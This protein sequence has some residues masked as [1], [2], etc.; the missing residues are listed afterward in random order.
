[1][2]VEEAAQ[3]RPAMA[4]GTG[5]SLL[6]YSQGRLANKCSYDAIEPARFRDT[7]ASCASTGAVTPVNPSRGAVVGPT[8]R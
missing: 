1:M 5:A 4:P 3:A 6:S 8:A 2:P 7:I